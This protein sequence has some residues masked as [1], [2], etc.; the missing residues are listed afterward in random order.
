VSIAYLINQYPQA[1]QS[2]IRREILA[3]EA[4]GL[5]IE[6]FTIRRWDVKLVDENDLKEQAKTR[7]VLDVGATGLLRAMI[8]ALLKHPGGFFGTLLY[9]CQI[10]W[11][12]VRGLPLHLI[13]FAEAC[14]LLE[15]FEQLNIRHVHA[16]FGTNSTTVAMFVRMLGGPGYSFTLHGPEEFDSPE[17]LRIGE[18]IRRAEFCAVISEFG[19]SQAYR[20]AQRRD[21]N[22]IHVIHCGLDEQF[23]RAQKSPPPSDP[24]LVCVGRFGETKGQLV[25]MEAAAKLAAQG[26]KFELLMIGDG[27]LRPDIEAAVA[28]GNLQNH[29][30]LLGWQSNQVVLDTLRNCRAL[31][32]PSFAEGLPV[33]FMESLAVQ[34]PVITTYIAGTPELVQPGISGWLVPASSVDPLVD[35]MREALEMP[36]E[37]LWEMGRAGF[38]IVEKNHTA[39]TEA[40]KL[41]ELFP[42]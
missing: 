6:R 16:H 42:R 7:V 18:K 29:V 39:T 37:Q 11:R 1:S 19:R 4:L 32:L 2:F 27:P 15:W 38:R 10:G 26:V 28:A 24:R 13:Y 34:R 23:L 17:F 22:K 21:W 35:A 40:R 41:L 31:V 5:P 25:L 14:V 12:S 9:A 3:L 8:R 30:K 36:V 20:W 33:V